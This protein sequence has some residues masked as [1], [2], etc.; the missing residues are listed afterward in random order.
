M[1]TEGKLS[2]SGPAE[3]TKEKVKVVTSCGDNKIRDIYLKNQGADDYLFA[4]HLK[5]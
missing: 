4:R 5:G 3:A 2:G 1:C